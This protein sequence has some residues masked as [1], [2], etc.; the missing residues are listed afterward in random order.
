MSV[1]EKL[2]NYLTADD[3]TTADRTAA[4]A[5][6]DELARTHLYAGT[7]VLVLTGLRPEQARG[8][9]AVV[10]VTRLLGE[11]MPQNREGT[12]VREVRDRGASISQ[13]GRVRYSDTRFGGDLH[14]DG[15]EAPLPA[16]DVFTLF[17]VRQAA[18]GGALRCVH[19]RDVERLLS[20]DVLATLREP[21][22]FDRRGDQRDGAGPTTVKPV[23]F[24]QHGRPSITYLRSYIEQ[25]HDHPG[26][27]DLTEG[28][29]KALDALDA[30]VDACAEAVV[31]KL[32]E[33][34]LALFDNLSV[35]HGRTEF[36]DAPDY[37]RLLLRTWVRRDLPAAS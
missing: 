23:L 16:P 9:R 12:L 7:G 1:C 21:F 22:H 34:E 24:T 10:R 19:V 36:Q 26:V 30:A 2:R 14:T 29:R 27:P 33:G 5:D 25:G 4:R 28:Q 15:A 13:R 3:V 18:D 32:N 37:T 31:G 20:D 11:P 35:L 6:L 17:C 8:E